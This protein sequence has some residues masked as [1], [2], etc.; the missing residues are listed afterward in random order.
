MQR[1]NILINHLNPRLDGSVKMEESHC[2]RAGL[3][4][5]PNAPANAA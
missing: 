3:L 1:W 4:L 5:P 2:P